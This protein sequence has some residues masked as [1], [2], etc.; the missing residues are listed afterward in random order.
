M[1]ADRFNALWAKKKNY[2]GEDIRD[3]IRPMTRLRSEAVK[4]KEV[5]SAN[6]EY[7]IKTEQLHADIDLVTKVTRAE[8]EEASK[9][10]LD[11]VTLPITQALEMANLKLEDIQAVELL[12]GGVRMP[13][14]KKVLK[15]YFE[16]AKL[17]LGQHLNGDE[18]MG[19]GAAFRAANIST[20]FRVRKVGIQDISTFGVSL[21][22]ET[23]PAKSGGF[24]GG[25]FGSGGSDKKSEDASEWSKHTSL[26]PRLSAVPSK[27][28]TV[29]FNYDQDILCKIEYDEDPLLPQ[30]TS[31]LLAVYNITGVAEFAKETE[32]KGLGQPKVHLSFTLDSSGVVSLN[33]A[34]ASVELPPEEPTEEEKAAAEA[35]A[36]AEKAADAETAA[37]ESDGDSSTD[38]EGNKTDTKEKSKKKDKKDK[39]KKVEKKDTHLRRTLKIEDNPSIISPPSWSEDE[40]DESKEKLAQLDYEDRQRK[41]KEA[42]L[43]E[44]EGYVY[45]VKNRMMDDETELSKVSTEEQRTSLSELAS[46]TSEWIDDEAGPNIDLTVYKLKLTDLKRPA[47]AMFKRYSELTDRPAA[48]AKAREQLVGVKTTVGKWTDTMPHVT[49]EEKSKLLDLVEKATTWLEDKEEAQSKQPVHEDPVFDSADVMPQ[50]K[51]VSLNFEKLLRKPKPPPPKPSKNETASTNGTDGN[52]TVS[53]DDETVSNSTDGDDEDEKTTEEEEKSEEDSKEEL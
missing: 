3:F 52:E 49:D 29:A 19:L 1:L 39:K 45:K 7:P 38:T 13:Y 40:L 48:V 4:I 6:N 33:K 41:A 18:A 32:S 2:N 28:K 22:L 26:Y 30:G 12:G 23:L 17:E 20:A 44:L 9:D 31:K 11:R 15:E 47:E 5:L 37:S 25:L 34:E 43:N 27:A 42:A 51:T 53:D 14:V 46:A 36:E 8:L 16:P 21:K 24:F 10:L 35:E 50:L